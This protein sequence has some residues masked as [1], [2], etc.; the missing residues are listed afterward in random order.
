MCVRA[1]CWLGLL[2][3]WKAPR[4]S[5]KKKNGDPAACG[6][7]RQLHGRDDRARKLGRE[8]R[9]ESNEARKLS[10]GWW[11]EPEREP[12]REREL[13]EEENQ[14]RRKNRGQNGHFHSRS[15]ASVETNSRN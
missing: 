9:I 11:G 7:E 3:P 10:V 14:R 2:V 13:K 5:Q 6:Q 8:D 12:D 15:H 4:E 1:C